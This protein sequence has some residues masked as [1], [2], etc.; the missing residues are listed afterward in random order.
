MYLI[1]K[2]KANNR[3]LTETSY[4]FTES[5]SGTLCCLLTDLS[6]NMIFHNFWR[7]LSWNEVKMIKWHLVK[8]SNFIWKSKILNFLNQEYNNAPFLYL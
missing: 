8:S 5:D 2:E 7:N 3:H 4:K 1:K 6:A